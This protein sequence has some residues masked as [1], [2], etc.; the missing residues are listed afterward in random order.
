MAPLGK[1]VEIKKEVFSDKEFQAELNKLHTQIDY[2]D[3]YWDEQTQR[4]YRFA[5]KGLPLA[6]IDSPKN[7]EYFLF[8][9]D[10]NLTLKGEKKLEG[11]SELPLSGFFKDGKLWS[12]VNVDDELG[13]AVFTF[14]F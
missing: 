6:N 8:A 14:D 5:S 2:W 13:F 3:F 11:F 10:R 4:Y 9:Y 7:F 1:N 12:Y